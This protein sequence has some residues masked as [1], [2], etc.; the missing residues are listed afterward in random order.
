MKR[1]SWVLSEFALPN[2]KIY[3]KGTKVILEQAP[4]DSSALPADNTYFIGVV[5][6]VSPASTEKLLCYHI[7]GGNYVVI[8]YNFTAAKLLQDVLDLDL[9]N[10]KIAEYTGQNLT[11][12]NASSIPVINS[13]VTIVT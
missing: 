8:S 13:T 5:T 12:P 6:I 11:Y 3:D 1:I 4:I 9:T 2:F 7:S 10:M